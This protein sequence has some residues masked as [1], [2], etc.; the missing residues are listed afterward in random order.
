MSSNELKGD[1]FVSEADKKM[2]GGGLFSFF[3]NK[4]EK[5]RDAAELY[6]KAANT[7]KL[8]KKWSKAGGAYVK[9]AE[10]YLQAEDLHDAARRF[11][12][13]STAYQKTDVELAVRALQRAL[14][15]YVDGGR[16]SIAAKAEKDIAEIYEAEGNLTSAAEHY[17]KSSDYYEMEGQASNRDSG[18][19]KVA[20]FYGSLG[21]YVEACELFEKVASACAEDKL[22]KFGVRDHL[23]KAGICYLASGDD[24]AVKKALDRYPS[25]SFE[26]ADSREAKFL[27][28]LLDA[29]IKHDEAGFSAAVQD[30]DSLSRLD[31]WKTS[32]LVRAKE[33]VKNEEA[34]LL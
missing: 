6:D 28:T 15:I 10:H 2:A 25:I 7:Y 12:D 5:A 19:L 18:L 33:A 8:D 3:G 4:K 26:W 27:A 22:R 17:Q 11:S 31:Q 21:K 29:T 34:E 1:A 14:D 32:I 23:L 20:H 9:S 16:F 24:V 13:A 30:Y